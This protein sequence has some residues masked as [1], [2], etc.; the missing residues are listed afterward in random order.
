MIII[1]S[2]FT[3][4]GIDK[5]LQFTVRTQSQESQFKLKLTKYMTGVLLLVYL[6]TCVLQYF[7]YMKQTVTPITDLCSDNVRPIFHT[8]TKDELRSG[9]PIFPEF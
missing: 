8:Q 1:G 6:Y 4:G 7:Y 3:G 5:F 2:K 9:G